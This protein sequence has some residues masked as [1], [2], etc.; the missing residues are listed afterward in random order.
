MLGQY[1]RQS[2]SPTIGLIT[3]PLRE[4]YT[5]LTLWG[6]VLKK[7]TLNPEEYL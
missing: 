5:D 2:Q 3:V 4:A 1:V 6:R 7:S